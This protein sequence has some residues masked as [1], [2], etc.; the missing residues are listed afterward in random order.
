ME[1]RGDGGREDK[2]VRS[3]D[4]WRGWEELDIESTCTRLNCAEVTMTSRLAIL[5]T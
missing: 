5:L 1:A 3:K 4:G 2:E